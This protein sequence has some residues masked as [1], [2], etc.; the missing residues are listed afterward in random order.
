MLAFYVDES[1][2]FDVTGAAQPWVVMLAVGFDDRHWS[3]IEQAMKALKQSYFPAH[4]PA[5]I[6]IRSNDVRT[7]HVH[8]RPANPFS[9]LDSATLRS[10]GADLYAVIDGLPVSWCAA[11]VHLPTAARILASRNGPVLYANSYRML[12]GLLDRWCACA[13]DTGR[14]FLD[15]R[16][17][18]LHGRVHRAIAVVHDDCR[19]AAPPG[20]ACIVERPYFHDS[21]RSNHIQIADVLA[22]NVMRRFRDA[23]PHY[24]YF[25]RIYSKLHRFGDNSEPALSVLAPETARI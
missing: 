19:R 22:Y 18:H 10:F 11:A 21:A 7:A 5:R 20:T 9:S 2:V 13:N 3:V 6:E 14:L 1:G 24:P 16:D 25:A 4:D 15:Q 17:A 23:D 12:L 8:P